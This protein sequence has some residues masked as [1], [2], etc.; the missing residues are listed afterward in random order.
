[1][2]YCV[3]CGAQV[4]DEAVVCIHCGCPCDTKKKEKSLRGTTLGVL[5]GIFAGVI[6]LVLCIILGDEKCKNG[7]I[8]AFI[9]VSIVEL[10]L[11]LIFFVIM[12]A[13]G[14]GTWY[15]C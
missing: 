12:L 5:L 13:V 3:H 9:T 10:C 4:E 1:M 7:A 15:T 2:K 11:A 6:G 8:K 14:Y